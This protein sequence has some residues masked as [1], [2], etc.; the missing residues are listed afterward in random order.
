MNRKKEINF[1]K[2]ALLG[3][4]GLLTIGLYVFY[5]GSAYLEP[6]QSIFLTLFL[7]TC[8]CFYVLMRSQTIT[9]SSAAAFIALFFVF[10]MYSKSEWRQSYI[11]AMNSQKG[12]YLDEYMDKYP[13][14]EQQIWIRLSGGPNWVDFNNEC[15]LPYLRGRDVKTKCVSFTVI[16]KEYG[17]DMK[18]E[19]QDH[20][21]KMKKT[22]QRIEKGQIKNVRQYRNC[23]LDKSCALVPMLPK[24]VETDKLDNNSPQYGN[25]RKAFWSIINDQNI[26]PEVCEFM[27]LCDLLIDL[28][29]I[30]PRRMNIN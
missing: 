7:V 3:T 30:D 26:T 27:R 1:P 16:E 8:C 13:T 6:G 14:W 20:F 21:Q 24:G 5:S 9:F 17:L 15:A 22:A 2:I 25:I 18:S 4:L 23:I 28:N 12:F 11:E 10:I 29:V 19:L